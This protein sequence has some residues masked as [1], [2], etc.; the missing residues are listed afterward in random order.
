MI[1]CDLQ[2]SREGNMQ[3]QVKSGKIKLD[4]FETCEEDGPVDAISCQLS[5]LVS[6][7]ITFS[8]VGGRCSG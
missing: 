1:Q 6:Q 3:D 2:E 5:S 7:L 4:L 8:G